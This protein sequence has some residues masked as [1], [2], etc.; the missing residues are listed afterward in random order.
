MNKNNDK[1]RGEVDMALATL[2][3]NRILMGKMTFDEV[4]QLLKAKVKQV[5]TEIDMGHLAE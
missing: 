1:K 2:M 4:P 5:L 3:A